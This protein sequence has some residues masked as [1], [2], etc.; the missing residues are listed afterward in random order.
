MS[1]HLLAYAKAAMT[2]GASFEQLSAIADPEF[3]NRG[4][5][6]ALILSEDYDLIWSHVLATSFTDARLNVP[7]INAIGRHHF[8]PGSRA[9]V[10]LTNPN[11]QDL[12]E[13]PLA[14]PKLEQIIAEASNNLGSSTEACTL[15]MAISPRNNRTN[16]PRG[17]RRLQLAFTGA[18]AGVAGAWSSL[19][20]VT[21]AENLRTGYYSVVGC[22]IFDAGTL[23]FRLVF[24]RAE[25]VNGKRMRPGG[26]CM[27]AVSNV[28]WA[29]QMGGLGTWG[30]FHSFEPPQLEIYA[31]ATASSAQVGI[32]DV[33]YEG[34]GQSY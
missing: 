34:E 5:T 16:I 27:E 6:P 4:A 3:S 18:V 32:L 10:I 26:L 14:L 28:P 30:R 29:P 33:V 1:F 24:P 23:A 22:N 11:V 17:Q 19:G 31:N 8:F 9:A 2:A 15:F 21:F 20:N 7:T 13:Y 12:R 25:M